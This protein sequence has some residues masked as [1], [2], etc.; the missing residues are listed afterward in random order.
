MNIEQFLAQT[1]AEYEESI[2]SKCKAYCEE[3][4][5]AVLDANQ[6]HRIIRTV[7]AGSTIREPA[8]RI[9]APRVKPQMDWDE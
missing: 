8:I 1:S 9:A 6:A 5:I 2:T 7:I 4:A 3:H